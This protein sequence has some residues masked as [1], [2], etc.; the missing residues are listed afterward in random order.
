M[1]VMM[2]SSEEHSDTHNEH[3]SNPYAPIYFNNVSFVSFWYKA[4]VEFYDKIN[5]EDRYLANLIIIFPIVFI[6]PFIILTSHLITS[7]YTHINS[8]YDENTIR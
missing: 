8:A 7:E 5:F 6:Q 4:L 3:T 1:F 2:T